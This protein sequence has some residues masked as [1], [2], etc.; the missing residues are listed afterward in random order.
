VVA[1]CLAES[2]SPHYVQRDSFRLKFLR[3]K[4]FD[5]KEAGIAMLRHVSIKR[6]LFG[7]A[8]LAKDITLKD[9]NKDDMACLGNGHFQILPVH[10]PAGRY[11]LEFILPHVR[12]EEASNLVRT[13]LLSIFC[14]DQK[15]LS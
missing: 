10:D 7:D 1:Y 9:L 5:A 4:Q 12:L 15:D 8:K 3:A 11:I 14:Q 13:L 6:E 2:Q